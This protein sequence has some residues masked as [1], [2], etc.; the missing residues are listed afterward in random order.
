MNENRI[1]KNVI[2]S[3]ILYGCKTRCLTLREEHRM[4]VFQNRVLRRIFKPKRV[5]IRGEWRK[6]HNEELCNLTFH[7]L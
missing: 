3:L 7:Q 6:L 1:C 4:R 2:L 5:R